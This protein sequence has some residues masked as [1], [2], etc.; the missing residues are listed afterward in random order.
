MFLLLSFFNCKPDLAI[1]QIFGF[2]AIRQHIGK[3]HLLGQH[4]FHDIGLMR[5]NSFIHQTVEPLYCNI[6]RSE[7]SKSASLRAC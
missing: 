7:I 4:L 2:G 1:A 3:V 6:I 5:L